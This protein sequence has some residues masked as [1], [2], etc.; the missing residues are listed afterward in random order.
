MVSNAGALD[1]TP[2]A[3]LRTIERKYLLED[4]HHELTERFVKDGEL[5]KNDDPT[6]HDYPRSL[7]H[8]MFAIRFDGLPSRHDAARW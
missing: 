7:D 6:R 4:T 3:T 8:N 5:E 1:F 2:L